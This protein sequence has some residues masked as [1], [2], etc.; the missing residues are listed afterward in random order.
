M[1]KVRRMDCS[2]NSIMISQGCILSKMFLKWGVDVMNNELTINLKIMVP[3]HSSISDISSPPPPL[4]F[5]R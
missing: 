1:R 2:L 3:Y 5:A 4:K